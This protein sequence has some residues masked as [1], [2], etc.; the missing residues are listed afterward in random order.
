MSDLNEHASGLHE[1]MRLLARETPHQGDTDTTHFSGGLGAHYQP[2][3]FIAFYADLALKRSDLY[4]QHYSDYSSGADNGYYDDPTGGG[5]Y[6]GS[7]VPPRDISLTGEQVRLGIDLQLGHALALQLQAEHQARQSDDRSL[8]NPY[9]LYHQGYCYSCNTI[10]PDTGRYRSSKLA[11]APGYEQQRVS[12][13]LQLDPARFVGLFAHAEH[14]LSL[15]QGFTAYQY[16]YGAEQPQYWLTQFEDGLYTDS[17]EAGIRLNPLFMPLDLYG[18]V[19]SGRFGSEGDHAVR[20]FDGEFDGI[21]ARL[22]LNEGGVFSSAFGLTQLDL[23]GNGEQFATYYNSEI[24]YSGGEHF[25]IDERL[26]TITASATLRFNRYIAL[27]AKG[28]HIRGTDNRTGTETRNS[29]AS[30]VKLQLTF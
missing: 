20:R 29:L 28:L 14:Q 1:G 4:Q 7:G 8:Y 27:Q 19:I 25:V 11:A 5:Y 15:W 10:D 17:L 23:S 2:A 12:L 13:A 30:Q 22:V 18:S 6:T 16:D 24:G 26:R 21:R 9:R 3:D